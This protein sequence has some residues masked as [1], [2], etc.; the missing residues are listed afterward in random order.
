MTALDKIAKAAASRP[1]RPTARR[2][3]DPGDADDLAA[4]FSFGGGSHGPPPVRPLVVYRVEHGKETLVRGLTLE[5]LLPRSFKE[6][7]ATGNEP[8]VYN[9]QDGG[10]RVLRGPLDDHRAGAAVPG[11]RRPPS[12]GQAPQTAG[13]SVAA[14]AAVAA[15]AFGAGAVAG[16]ATIG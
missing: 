11:R 4:L 7:A 12:A 5:N 14:G 10:G 1:T 2:R 6:V 13:V 15:R 3:I 9:Y 16:I 8:V